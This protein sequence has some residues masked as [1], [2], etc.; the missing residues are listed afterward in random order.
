MRLQDW[1]FVLNAIQNKVCIVHQNEIL[2]KQY[3]GGQSISKTVNEEDS[4]LILESKYPILAEKN[5]LRKKIK[6]KKK[7][8]ESKSILAYIC[9]IVLTVQYRIYG[10]HRY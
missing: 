1:D 6:L 8:V 3:V 5:I 7:V 4:Y 2:V 10:L 9:Y